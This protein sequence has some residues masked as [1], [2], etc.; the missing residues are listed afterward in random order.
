M[1]NKMKQLVIQDKVLKKLNES[2]VI[3]EDF[4]EFP[5]IKILN[6]Q[7]YF[8]SNSQHNILEIVNSKP[9][10]FSNRLFLAE[11]RVFSNTNK[12]QRAKLSQI[13]SSDSKIVTVH[14]V[15]S[16]VGSLQ[17]KWVLGLIT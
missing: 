4:A 5:T 7:L 16:L 11:E 3:L 13:E 9:T 10:Y 6:G 12:Y 1:A 2:V 14:N 17:N 8:A 15:H